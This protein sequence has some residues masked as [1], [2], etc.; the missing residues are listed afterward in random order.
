M[1]EVPTAAQIAERLVQ[2]G[3]ERGE[4]MHIRSA[5]PGQSLHR[6]R[7]VTGA[8]GFTAHAHAQSHRQQLWPHG[9]HITPPETLVCSSC[10]LPYPTP[11]NLL[12]ATRMITHK[13]PPCKCCQLRPS[14]TPAY[15]FPA[16]WPYPRTCWVPPRRAWAC[17]CR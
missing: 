2:V 10:S 5:C 1:G 11:Q 9:A 6:V 8:W 3:S 7:E 4:H 17:A 12:G 15:T 16:A 13:S 14:L